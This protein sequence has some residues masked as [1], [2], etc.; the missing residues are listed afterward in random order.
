MRAVSQADH[1]FMTYDNLAIDHESTRPLYG[2]SL[3]PSDAARLRQVRAMMAADPAHHR[4]V[5]ELAV[6]AV[7]LTGA[8]AAGIAVVGEAE[9]HHRARVGSEGPVCGV[10]D[11]PLFTQVFATGEPRWVSEANG[12]LGVTDALVVPVCTQAGLVALL[13]ASSAPAQRD[14]ALLDDLTRVAH[15]VA[16]EVEH[17]SARMLGGPL[18]DERTGLYNLHGFE[19]LAEQLLNLSRR[20]KEP[21]SVMLVGLEGVDHQ[22]SIVVEFA[23][24]LRATF[25]G[26]DVVARLQG[27]D[28]AALVTHCDLE[29]SHSVVTR[30]RGHMGRDVRWQDVRLVAGIVADDGHSG[31]ED[32]LADAVCNM[33]HERPLRLF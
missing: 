15:L 4:A 19:T 9:M 32:L 26:S 3:L 10:L 24:V 22:G 33:F 16:R 18:L 5:E 30:L 12:V 20:R 14:M 27:A 2:T 21:A 31:L 29:A 25:R 28:F 13:W 23:R 11:D 1:W 8:S 6:L 7:R 17:A